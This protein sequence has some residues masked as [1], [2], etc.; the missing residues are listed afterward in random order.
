MEAVTVPGSDMV[1]ESGSSA[2][3]PERLLRRDLERQQ[4]AEKRRQEKERQ[5]VDEEKR[6]FFQASFGPERDALEQLLQSGDDPGKEKGEAELQ[7]AG[8]RLQTL[9][10]LL[11]D[12]LRFLPSY[13]VKQA[14]DALQRLQLALVDRRQQLQPKK[15]FAFKSRGRKETSSAPAPAPVEPITAPA[16]LPE[17]EH[18][19]GFRGLEGQS[20][21]LSGEELNGQDVQLVNLRD[22]RVRLQGSPG[23]LHL[24]GLR[25]CTVL[26]GPVASS[27]FMDECYSCELGFS[28]QQLRV[29]RSTDTRIYLHVTCRAIIEDC[30]RLGFAPLTWN[31]PGMDEDFLRAGLDRSRNHWSQVDDFDWLARDAASPNW[32]I[33]PEEERRMQW[34]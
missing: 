16:P 2:V 14:Q 4:E 32:G 13:D 17:P 7:E 31:Y 24:R 9:Q 28:C 29:H 11:N 8:V 21:E 19:C 10:K 30:R 6:D 26:C 25:G 12:S 34:D 20:L 27:V 1:L 15:K 33:V 22:C 23:T 3:L 18:T 5:T